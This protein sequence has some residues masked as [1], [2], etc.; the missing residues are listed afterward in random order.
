MTH[1]DH[2]AAVMDEVWHACVCKQTFL[3]PGR[4]QGDDAVPDGPELVRRILKIFYPVQAEGDTLQPLS[5]LCGYSESVEPGCIFLIPRLQGTAAGE[6]MPGTHNHL[7]IGHQIASI[8]NPT[9]IAFGGPLA[10]TDDP[11]PD[12]SAFLPLASSDVPAAVLPTSHDRPRS[13]SPVPSISLNVFSPGD[14]VG[15]GGFLQGEQIHLVSCSLTAA[16]PASEFQVIRLL[17]IGTYAAVYLVREVLYRPSEN[18]HGS[19][20]GAM[21]DDD[22]IIEY[23]GDYA[24]KCL[25]KINLDDDVYAA[26]MAEVCFSYC[27]L[28]VR[29]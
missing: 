27:S 5:K 16:Q 23:G 12:S 1:D 22:D 8:S 11:T 18:G 29:R 9:D 7:N 10:L 3:R 25:S 6:P 13:P 26:Q 20:I 28:P 14:F 21:N 24:I 15:D 19:I 4:I 2:W 17:G